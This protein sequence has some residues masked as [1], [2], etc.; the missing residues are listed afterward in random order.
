M[1]FTHAIDPVAFAV[2]PFAVRWYGLSYLAGIG[3]TWWLLSR[4][5]HALGG[6]AA[7]AW[8][9]DLVFY[10]AVGGVLG[11]RLG[12]ILFYDLPAYLAAPWKV[13]AVWEGGMSFHGG[14]IGF[15]LALLWLARRSGHG[16]LALGDALVPVVPLALF[17]G[18]LGNFANGELW[19]VPTTL[20]WGVVF[21][22]A[23]PEPRHPTQIYQA[24]LEGLLLFLLLWWLSRRP[25]PRGLLTGVF[26]TGYALA[27]GLV[28]IWRV[29]D[30]HIGHLLGDWLTMGQL[31]SLPMFAIGLLLIAQARGQPPVNGALALL[32]RPPGRL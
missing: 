20:P 31:L 28:E 16:L 2:G 22:L 8:V 24:S 26:L 10:A 14:A 7:A 1:A 21:P 27:R 18:R 25:L 29:P 9:A 23:G 12:Y 32:P 11:G 15:A 6:P 4:R 17:F 3:T 19:G 30:A 13:L 5:A